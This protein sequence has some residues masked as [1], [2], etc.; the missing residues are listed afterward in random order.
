MD[1][2]AIVYCQLCGQQIVWISGEQ[3]YQKYVQ[4]LTYKVH[5]K[6]A[7]DFFNAAQHR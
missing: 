3:S 1:L 4:E 2:T 7:E 5:N 6:C